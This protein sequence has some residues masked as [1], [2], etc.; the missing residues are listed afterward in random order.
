M[1]MTIDCWLTNLVRRCLMLGHLHLLQR[2]V[3]N[4]VC[5]AIILF[6]RWAILLIG[7]QP[8]QQSQGN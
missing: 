8:V 7:D 2:R 4:V 6:P 1:C 5:S 3:S